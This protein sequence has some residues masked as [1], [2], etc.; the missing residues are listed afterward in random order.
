MKA[1]REER[2]ESLVFVPDGFSWGAL[3]F[4]PF[5]FLVKREWAGLLAFVVAAI[6]M[7][8]VLSLVDANAGAVM[9]AS[10]VLAV[11]AGFEANE[12]R[13]ASLSFFG[14][15][16]IAAVTGRSLAECEHRFFDAWLA[17][18]PPVTPSA[19]RVSPLAAE[20]RLGTLKRAVS[21]S[22]AAAMGRYERFSSRF[23][24][25]S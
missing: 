15:R 1:S 21:Q 10:I 25:K 11:L 14:W 17:S 12:I 19:W 8:G 18:E 22:R 3:L 24:S 7:R 9:V 13:R 23:T 4:G 20:G 2:A 6:A 5:Y 16:E